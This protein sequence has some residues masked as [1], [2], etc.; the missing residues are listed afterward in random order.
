M[1]PR[2][3]STDKPV[4]NLEADF[5]ETSTATTVASTP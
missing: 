4:S 2:K 5:K 3:A 1:A